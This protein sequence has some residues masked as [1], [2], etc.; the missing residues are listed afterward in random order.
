MTVE[1]VHLPTGEPGHDGWPSALHVID[2]R[3]P[4]S[5]LGAVRIAAAIAAA[6]GGS[7][8]ILFLGPAREIET[9]GAVA[10]ET[11]AA[12]GTLVAG[13]CPPLGD[14]TLAVRPLRR[15]IRAIEE[16]GD[17]FEVLVGWGTAPAVATALAM[18]D[19]PRATVSTVGAI[20]DRRLVRL[21]RLGPGAFA[22]LSTEAS[23]SFVAASPAFG[24]IAELAVPSAAWR[25]V[26][27]RAA[28][29]AAWN[30]D[31]RT[32]VVGILGDDPRWCD[33]KHAIDSAGFAAPAGVRCILVVSPRAAR[34]APAREWTRT[35]R[36]FSISSLGGGDPRFWITDARVDRPWSIA[37][38]LDAAYLPGDG[39]ATAGAAAF[40]D[41]V[42]VLD[43]LLGRLASADANGRPIPVPAS[44]LAYLCAMAVGVPVLGD[45]ATAPA[46]ECDDS[47]S[48]LGDAG[49]RV[50][51]SRAVLSLAD[52]RTALA[53]MAASA[54]ERLGRRHGPDAIDRW[55]RFLASA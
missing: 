4:G 9:A 54:R 15:A 34:L 51:A 3:S 11:G 27:D 53:A 40:A 44:P 2:A 50:A 25:P 14:P 20:P 30:V 22:C 41:R 48:I 43:R 49:D 13:P 8:R 7:H 24:P 17:K 45:R 23:R 33:L 36:D 19:R 47:T 1:D 21:G 46:A 55:R 16:S 35:L 42:G 5:G 32:V 29:R 26:G 37:A 12:A 10:A 6:A 31:E 38:G 18:P 52:N 28:I 39:I